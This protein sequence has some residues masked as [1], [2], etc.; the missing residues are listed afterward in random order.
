MTAILDSDL[1]AVSDQIHRE[2]LVLDGHLDVPPG[3]GEGEL[4]PGL[5]GPTQV[6][7]PKL[8]K[9]GMNAAVF[10]VSIRTGARNPEAFV[11]AKKDADSKLKSILSI[12]D[13]Y[14]DRAAIA[15][16]AED[17]S[18]IRQEGRVA[19]IL[20]VLNAYPF[21]TDLTGFEEYYDA[22]V[23][24]L[25]FVHA[26]NNDFA[27]SSRPSDV[28]REEHGGLAQVSKDA[29]PYLN[30]LGVLIDVS[31]LTPAGLYQTLELSTA[32]VIASHSSVRGIAEATRNLSDEEL[33]AIKAG[34]GVVNIVAFGFYL[35]PR[36]ATY[37]DDV[38]AIRK[39][40]GLSEDFLDME[41]GLH[42]LTRD[43]VL[44]YA[45]EV[46]GLLPAAGVPELV[47]A[48]D[49]VV[50]RIGIEHVGIA[51][52][53]NHGGGINGYANVAEAPNVTAELVRRGYS[54]DQIAALWGG[55]FL[56]VFDQAQARG[57]ALRGES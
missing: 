40:F 47:N 16:T 10:S 19:I 22:G 5:E 55:N 25:G 24:V 23:R 45:G 15:K 42:V 30:R 34:G 49:Y 26:G 41:E 54:K 43:Q 44:A 18:R 1:Q 48:I 51:T 31:Q 2:I 46:Y 32:P 6:D 27:D 21:G 20:G 38:K 52:D 29:I 8:E 17:V 14:P 50:N 39:K 11:T 33:D 35:T 56:R 9:G 13:R 4:D 53:F 36:P 3:Y 57:K 37:H 28:P 7:L 12:A